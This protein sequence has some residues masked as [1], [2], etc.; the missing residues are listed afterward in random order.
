MSYSPTPIDTSVITLP[1]ELHAL[2]KRYAENACD[3]WAAQRLP[4]GWFFGPQRADAKKFHPCRVPYGELP[5]KE[6]EF[7]RIAALGALKAI[8]ALGYRILPPQS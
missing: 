4:H 5:E 7:D 6:K 2:T 3:L 8:L 1:L